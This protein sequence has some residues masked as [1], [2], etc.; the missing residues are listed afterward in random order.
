MKT[1]SFITALLISLNSYSHDTIRVKLLDTFAIKLDHRTYNQVGAPQGATYDEYIHSFNT[2]ALRYLTYV[3]GIKRKS[4]T[5]YDTTYYFTDTAYFKALSVGVHLL[6]RDFEF[7]GETNFGVIPGVKPIIF[8]KN[9]NYSGIDSIYIKVDT[10]VTKT[11][12]IEDDII[13]RCNN[14]Y[15]P[16]SF[17]PES[18]HP[19]NQEF[20]PFNIRYKDYTMNIWNRWG[21][22]LC[23]SKDWDGT[24]R[25]A[26]QLPGTYVYQILIKASNEICRGTVNL[27]RNETQFNPGQ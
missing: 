23:T 12:I 14:I 27:I 6:E 21:D 24:F 4:Y 19:D 11:I 26:P 5:S 16:N 2:D 1:L 25:G 20:H 13:Y 9:R 22:L 15:I 7:T 10:L 8:Y 18:E 17:N 3:K